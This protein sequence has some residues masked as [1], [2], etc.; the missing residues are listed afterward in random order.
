M[1]SMER[2]RKLAAV[3]L[4]FSIYL[5]VSMFCDF[6]TGVSPGMILYGAIAL[7]IVNAFDSVFRHVLHTELSFHV[8]AADLVFTIVGTYIGNRFD[9]YHRFFFYDMILHFASGGLIV[10]TCFEVFFPEPARA[11]L[12][13][14]LCLFI[15][16]LIGIAGAAIWE[17][18]EFTVDVVTGLDVQ[19]NL[20]SEWEIFGRDWQNPGLKDTMND[21]I[22]GSIGSLAGTIILLVSGKGRKKSIAS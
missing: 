5:L 14:P 22:I 7:F 18:G 11:L 2:N 15:I 13:P 12:P 3:R 6:I 19:R 1:A 4:V 9:L 17:I 10:L 20:F 21:M 16:L 8:L